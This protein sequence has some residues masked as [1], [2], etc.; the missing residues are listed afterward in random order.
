[1]QGDRRHVPRPLLK[2][3]RNGTHPVRLGQRSRTL[4]R[5]I[6]GTGDFLT[7]AR[8]NI[9]VEAG[10]LGIRLDRG[11][12]PFP[13]VKHISPVKGAGG[14]EDAV[15][16]GRHA[17]VGPFAGQPETTLRIDRTDGGER[18]LGRGEHDRTALGPASRRLVWNPLL[19]SSFRFGPFHDKRQRILLG[20]DRDLETR[21]L[22]VP[23]ATRQERRHGTV[24]IGQG[25]LNAHAVGSRNDAIRRLERAHAKAAVG[26][27]L[28]ARSLLAFDRI[29]FHTRSRQL[30]RRLA[31]GVHDLAFHGIQLRAATARHGNEQQQ[32]RKAKPFAVRHATLNRGG[33]FGRHGC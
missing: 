13:L 1:M 8:F 25:R 22:E 29:E 9:D 21:S 10:R 33:W 28:A 4:L 27:D 6:D 2:I 17:V 26:L 14:D 19:I 3:S 5:L 32:A 24:E 11:R 31:I 15:V 16:P 23:V 18:L 7:R 20:F 12:G 30:D